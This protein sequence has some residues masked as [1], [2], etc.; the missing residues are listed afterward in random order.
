[1]GEIEKSGVLLFF[2]SDFKE[3]SEIPN[4]YSI[5]GASYS[6][7]QTNEAP[8]YFLLDMSYMEGYPIKKVLCITSQIVKNDRNKDG[9]TSYE[10]FSERFNEY[11]SNK[12]YILQW[13][14]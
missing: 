3:R 14:V 12:G 11:Y 13:G 1:M 4:N 8:T 7:R 5:N 9:K 10:I 2:L 6:G